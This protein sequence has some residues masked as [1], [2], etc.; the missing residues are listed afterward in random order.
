MYNMFLYLEWCNEN[1]FPLRLL[2]YFWFWY[3]YIIYIIYQVGAP[4]ALAPLRFTVVWLHVLSLL[5]WAVSDDPRTISVAFSTESYLRPSCLT[6]RPTVPTVTSG[7]KIPSACTRETTR[8]Q[9]LKIR[10][11]P[12]LDC[13]HTLNHSQLVLPLGSVDD[14]PTP[15]TPPPPRTG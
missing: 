15:P 6:Q 10:L 11:C 9:F 14:T 13:V 8:I 7:G 5:S 12:S 2:K 3:I 4:F 1:N